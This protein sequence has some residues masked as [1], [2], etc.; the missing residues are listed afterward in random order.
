LEKVRKRSGVQL[1]SIRQLASYEAGFFEELGL[2]YYVRFYNLFEP[3]FQL[4][5]TDPRFVFMT[6]QYKNV[7]NNCLRVVRDGLGGATILGGR[8]SGKSSVCQIL[9]NRLTARSDYL[10]AHLTDLSVTPS[11]LMINILHEFG[12]TS[13]SRQ[14]ETLKGHFYNFLVEETQGS[15]QNFVILADDT[16]TATK[17]NLELL[18]QLLG[19]E[20]AGEK[21]VQIIL[22]GQDELARKIA[23]R[24]ALL[25]RMAMQMRLEKLGQ[26]ESL[27]LVQ[28]RLGSAGAD[29]EI[30][31]QEALLA[32]ADF[33]KGLPQ[34]IC[35]IGYYALL[36]GASRNERFISLATV[37][38]A[39]SMAQNT[40]AK[41]V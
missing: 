15:G 38:E 23:A 1:L 6:E 19:F 18:Q 14:V 34:E 24:P 11:Q 3:P 16:Q 31:S 35:K 28:H 13:T 17:Y 12:Q 30:F 25:N 41:A 7:I 4:L 26:T 21:L 29:H 9:Y 22:F 2:E 39:Y 33:A 37:E 32:L 20:A 40:L 5:G 36:I 27:M 10:I 8:G